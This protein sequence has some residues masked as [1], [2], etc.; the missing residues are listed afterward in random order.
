MAVELIGLPLTMRQ[1][2]L[3]LAIQGRAA[4]AGITE[5]SMVIYPGIRR[6]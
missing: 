6:S 5:K 3:S 4:L 1:A 2:V